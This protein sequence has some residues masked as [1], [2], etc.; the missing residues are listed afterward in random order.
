MKVTKLAIV[1]LLFSLS[2]NTYAQD[3]WT[4]SKCITTA[5]E[6]NLTLQQASAT[7]GLQELN[8]SQTKQSQYPN[9]NGGSDVN[10]NF[11]RSID[12]VTN[13]FNAETFFSNRLFLGSSATIY[14][15]GRIRNQIKQADLQHQ[16][17]LLNL[18]QSQRDISLLVAQAYVNALFAQ[19]NL[20]IVKNQLSLAEEQLAQLDRLITVG[21]RP[22]NDR[23]NLVANTLRSKQNIISAQNNVDN[24]LLQLKQL[25]RIDLETEIALL[26]P[27]KEPTILIDPNEISLAELYKQALKTQPQIEAGLMSAEAASLDQKIAQAGLKPSV[28]AQANVGTNYSNKGIRLLGFDQEFINQNVTIDGIPVE[29]Q[30]PRDVAIT[31]SNPYFNQLDENISYGV[32]VSLQVPIYNNGINKT[33]IER[34]KL[35]LLG[36]EIQNEQQKDQLKTNV[37]QALSNARAAK[38]ELDFATQTVE[39]LEASFTN[40][41]KR[42]DLGSMNT[43]DYLDIKNQLDNAQLSLIIAKYDYLFKSKVIDFYMGQPLNI[44]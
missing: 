5:M 4:L 33:N 40:A 9:L 11:G 2:L 1:F 18:N 43:L 34:A 30:L 36:Q 10:W 16:A 38:L 6:N 39:A 22:K 23:L 28:T 42:F 21:T 44:N 17:A 31:E 20:K 29:L 32:G 37:Q 25:I 7:V 35:N 15:G 8:K 26:V 27:A 13:T 3:Q 19:E 24:A 12:P 41:Q 14:N